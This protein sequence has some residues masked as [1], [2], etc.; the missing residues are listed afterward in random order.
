MLHFPA[1]L[2]IF[3]RTVC[4]RRREMMDA[5][6]SAVSGIVG[7]ILSSED[8]RRISDKLF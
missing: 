2:T 5:S 1:P 3:E 4:G 8:R 7:C 6:G